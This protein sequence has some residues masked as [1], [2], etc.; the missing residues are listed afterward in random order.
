MKA[1]APIVVFAYKRKDKIKMCLNSLERCVDFD[2]SDIFIFSD[3]PRATTDIECVK[4]VRDFLDKY[5]KYSKAKNVKVVKSTENKGLA[6][7]IID[8]VT[9][10]IN[11]YGKAIVVEDDLVVSV[12]FLKY[13]NSA[14][15]YY[16]SDKTY[17]MIS[18][19]TYDFPELEKY[20]HQIYA[21][22]KGDCWGW[23]T[24]SDRWENVDWELKNMDDYLK[25]R[26]WRRGFSHLEYGLEDQLIRQYKKELN[27]WAA[28]WFFHLYNNNYLTIYPKLCRAINIGND[29]SGEN[30][31]INDKCN[32]T[33]NESDERIT[34]E[35]VEANQKFQKC[36]YKYSLPSKRIRI[37]SFLRKMKHRFIR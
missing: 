19:Y 22:R 14:L 7:S 34:F 18:A 16:E 26:K 4:T 36:I 13:M 35:K 20:N 25:D 6:K 12:D 11:E 5:L 15:N 33:L 29:D 30:C 10:I 32:T 23:A 17:G 8:G 31:S 24:W 1:F 21:L 27:A 28:R 3:G 37:I 2:K 9:T